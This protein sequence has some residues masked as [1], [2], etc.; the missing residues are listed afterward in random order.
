MAAGPRTY[1]GGERAGYV[2]ET[3]ALPLSY[4]RERR[5][6]LEP[7]RTGLLA[8]EGSAPMAAGFSCLG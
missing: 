5:A 1:D 2:Y 7:A 6:G 4:L 8:R 3:G